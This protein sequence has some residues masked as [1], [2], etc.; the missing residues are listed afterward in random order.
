MTPKLEV[1]CSDGNPKTPGEAPRFPLSCGLCPRGALATSTAQAPGRPPA[2]PSPVGSRRSGGWPGHLQAGP[3]AV[4]PTLQHTAETQ[5]RLPC[6]GRRAGDRF[7]L[8]DPGPAPHSFLLSPGP[9]PA[10]QAGFLEAPGHLRADGSGSTA[11]GWERASRPSPS[12]VPGAPARPRPAA[13]GTTRPSSTPR[14]PVLPHGPHSPRLMAPRPSLGPGVGH[15]PDS[16]LGKLRP[17]VDTR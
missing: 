5:G 11:W 12:A 2:P 15:Q 6:K 4:P 1:G 9:R 16:Q 14:S 8:G 17:A 7:S 10:A 3:A 13:V